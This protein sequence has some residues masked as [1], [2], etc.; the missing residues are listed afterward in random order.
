MCP[1]CG[2]VNVQDGRCLRCGVVVSL[3]MEALD[4]MRRG[5]ARPAAARPASPAVAGPASGATA[6]ATAPRPA[7]RPTATRPPALDG[8]A[9]S[10]PSEVRR[11]T[12][13]GVGGSLFGIWTVNVLWT[14]LTLGGYH[15][16]AKVRLRRYVLNQT[17][18]EGDRFAYHGTGKELLLGFL[19]AMLLFVAP[20]VLLNVLPLA[21]DGGALLEV[22]V[23]L[24]TYLVISIFVPV[25]MVGARRYR[26]SRT[27]WRGIR[28]SFRGQAWE[29]VKLFLTGSMLVSL[30]LGL[31]YP[32]F[33]TARRRFMVGH[34]YFGQRPFHFDGRGRALMRPYLLALLLTLP[35]LGLCWF[36]YVARKR[37]Y[38]WDHTAFEGARFHSTMTGRGLLNLIVGNFLLLVISLGVAWPWVLVRNAHF[39]LLHV[40][41]VGALEL[42]A[43]VQEPQA[44]VATGDALSAFFGADVGLA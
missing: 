35:T 21:L 42:D 10:G 4:K 24:L 22:P 43:I 27:S 26:L 30:T 3:Y 15:F 6:V 37:R 13:H 16:W 36:W 41:L 23:R 29:F 31:Y 8:L 9:A 32:V 44:E 19:R 1:K 28:F 5:P 39:N 20:I 7:A 25:A 17:E 12:F 11:F 33:D 14:L 40:Q 34:S 18:L 38:F 2:S